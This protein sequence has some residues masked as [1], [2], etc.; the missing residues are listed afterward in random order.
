M[1]V[2]EWKS[3]SMFKLNPDKTGF[4]IFTCHAQ[5]KKLYSHLPLRIVC[6]FIHP[7]VVVNNLGVWLDANFFFTDHVR[8]IYKTCFIQLCDDRQVRQYLTAEAAFLVATA[9][10][11]TAT[12]SSEDCKVS[13]ALY[14]KHIR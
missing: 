2:Q 14:S 7:A 9:L 3:S 6:N 12:L 8:N 4:I 1:D 10:V 13:T 5:L 11:G